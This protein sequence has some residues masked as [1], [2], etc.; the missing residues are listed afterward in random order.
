VQPIRARIKLISFF[1]IFLERQREEKRGKKR[2]ISRK[3]RRRKKKNRVSVISTGKK[4]E[5]PQGIT[6]GLKKI[7]RSN[8]VEFRGSTPGYEFN[9][10]RDDWEYRYFRSRMIIS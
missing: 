3:I 8:S 1:S 5:I 9:S 7:P 10:V 6:P 4:A 2:K